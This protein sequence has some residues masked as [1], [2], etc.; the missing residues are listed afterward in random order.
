MHIPVLL[1]EILTALAPTPGEFI[2]DGTFG[3]GGHSKAILEKIGPTGKLLALDW[4]EAAILRN[5]KSL[6]APNMTCAQGN[7]AQLPEIL[8]RL[9]LPK[10]DGLLID[11]G[12]SSEQIEMSGKGF[13]FRRSEPLIMTY[14]SD[15][16]P[17]YKLLASLREQELTNILREF[18]EERYAYRI[19][20]AIAERN[21]RGP[22]IRTSDALAEIVTKAV[23]KNYERGRIHPATR[24]FQALRIYANH[25]LD[26][27]K[28]ILAAV[29]K[30]L[31]TG[32]RVAIITFHSLED[33]IV[34][35]TFRE[36]SQ[37][38]VVE[39][40]NKKPIIPSDEEI[41]HNVRSRS[42]K[43]RAARLL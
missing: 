8:E 32:G 20:T 15:S 16:E 13:S 27:L 12:F 26:N 19:A 42:A 22:L 3:G 9:G 18:G 29:P 1:N 35:Q 34:K 28:K 43:L 21:H 40:F 23:P 38:G 39:L 10:A 31:K 41:A 2:I 14:G 11:L 36:M 7:Y 5:C 30:I 37:Q 17:V 33:R 24:T 6:E 25:E 4:E